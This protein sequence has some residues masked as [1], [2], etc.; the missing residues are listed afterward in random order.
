MTPKSQ[1]EIEKCVF[2]DICTRA[3]VDIID[4]EP[5]NPV[6]KG[7]RIVF[8]RNHSTDFTDDVGT[9]MRVMQHASELAK[10]L[11]GEYNLITSKGKNAT[12]SVFHLHVHLVPR[13]EN[14]GLHLPWTPNIETSYQQGVEDMRRKCVVAVVKHFVNNKFK[15]QPLQHEDV[16][17]LIKN[18]K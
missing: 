16:T 6:V 2:C 1:W 9:T 15:S 12:Q 17:T 5:L 11:G 13:M 18:V 8:A 3:G 10:K 14:D 4:I 7:H